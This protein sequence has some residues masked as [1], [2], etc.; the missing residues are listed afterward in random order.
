VVVNAALWPTD[1]E[2]QVENALVAYAAQ[3][4]S[5]VGIT[6]GYDQVG[7]VPGA[8][9]YASELVIPVSSIPG[10]RILAITVGLA[11][12]PTG[13]NVQIPWNQQAQVLATNITVT[14]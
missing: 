7:F 10:I 2:T 3:G 6:T 9:V 4:A 5:A 1:G 13:D 8:S 11:A 14:V 12:N